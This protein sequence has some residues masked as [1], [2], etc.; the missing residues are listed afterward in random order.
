MAPEAVIHLGIGTLER[1][2]NRNAG[3]SR[4][5]V[6]SIA[7]RLLFSQKRGRAPHAQD[8]IENAGDCSQHENNFQEF[9]YVMNH[10]TVRSKPS[11]FPSCTFVPLVGKG[12][13]RTTKDTKVH[14]EKIIR[15]GAIQSDP[16]SPLSTPGKSQIPAPRKLPHGNESPPETRPGDRA[17]N[18]AQGE[19]AGHKFGN[20][21]P[22][23]P[24]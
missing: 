4:C 7:C 18:P 12:T 17:A 11:R 15:S 13:S 24:L 6:D 14:E 3:Q 8:V 16:D 22:Q 5:W 21:A 9:E 10:E 2:E 19:D 20:K 1:F 23:A